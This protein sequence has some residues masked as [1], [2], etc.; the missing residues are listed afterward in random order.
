[1]F[2]YKPFLSLL[3][4]RFLSD[5]VDPYSLYNAYRLTPITIK[6]WFHVFVIFAAVIIPHLAVAQW[7]SNRNTSL[8][9]WVFAIC[10]GALHICMLC[11]LTLPYYWLIQY[12]VSMGITFKRILGLLFGLVGYV[13]LFGLGTSWLYSILPGHQYRRFLH[14]QGYEW[15]TAEEARQ[16]LRQLRWNAYQVPM[17][18]DVDTI[19]G[20]TPSAHNLIAF[21]RMLAKYRKAQRK[22]AQGEIKH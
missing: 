18:C 17:A 15:A 2:A 22:Q 11:I 16:I 21:M 8:G 3:S 6:Q 12:T 9:Y 14:R 7:I 4:G 10:K 20:S 5:R 1:M 13:A 19:P